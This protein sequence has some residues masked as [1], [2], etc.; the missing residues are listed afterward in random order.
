MPS[1]RRCRRQE[2]KIPAARRDAKQG[3]QCCRMQ[4]QSRSRPPVV[5]TSSRCPPGSVVPVPGATEGR[6]RRRQ[7]SAG[8]RGHWRTGHRAAHPTRPGDRRG[9]SDVRSRNGRRVRWPIRSRP[10]TATTGAAPTA[11]AAPG[12][13]IPSWMS[14]RIREPRDHGADPFIDRCSDDRDLAS[15]ELGDS[16]QRQPA[17]R[18]ASGVAGLLVVIDCDG[19]TLLCVVGEGQDRVVL[20][21]VAGLRRVWPAA[22]RR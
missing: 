20:A 18:G 19:A 2:P 10:H 3:D 14:R 12:G 22:R 5:G 17:Q 15:L 1:N 9:G 16:C 6:A 13:T 7:R 4:P 8:P 21:R 11:T